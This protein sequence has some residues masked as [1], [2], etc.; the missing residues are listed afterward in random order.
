MMRTTMLRGLVVAAL[1]LP[2]PAFAQ[3]ARLQLDRLNR[4]A[5]KAKEVV[6]V[7]L[8][9]SM[10]QQAASLGGSK[11]DEKTRSLLKHLKGVYVKSFEFADEA[12]YTDDDVQAIRSQLQ[13]P[14]WSRNVS[15]REDGELTEIYTWREGN[16]AAG[17]AVL[18]AEPR[19]LTVVN[20]VGPIDVTQ[21]S[22]LQGLVG[23][24]SRFGALGSPSA[25]D[26][27]KTK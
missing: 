22:G 25:K 21:L 19:E 9:A 16:A 11:M 14:G 12:A 2:A 13:A 23:A 20:L 26:K 5:D 24:A 3:G 6:D 27:Q 7:S 8:D 18:T 15:V 1:L 4:L 17:L 10:L